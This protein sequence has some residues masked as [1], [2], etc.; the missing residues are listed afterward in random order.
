MQKRFVLFLVFLM[1]TAGVGALA[2]GK[3]AAAQKAAAPAQPATTAAPPAPAKESSKEQKEAAPGPVI[4]QQADRLLRQMSDY[5]KAAKQFSFHAEISYDD[6]LPSGQKLQLAATDEV[7]VRRPDRIYSEFEGETGGKRFWYD[8]KTITLYDSKHHVYG[9]E[10]APATIDAVLD[11]L[12][13]VLGFSPPFSDLL[14]SDPYAI[15]T[16]NVQYGFYAG[17]TQVEG[18]RCHHLAFQEKKIDWQVWIE[19]GVQLVPCKLVITYKTL[20]GAPQFIAVFSHWDLMAPAPDSMFAANLPASADRIT[21][22]AT[23]TAEKKAK[24]GTP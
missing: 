10:E 4:G 5:L 2:Y 12:M 14:H 9:T 20:P 24:G 11:H 19:D 17:L 15:L 21:F 7:L 6:L 13:K 22:Q 3:Q 18:Q 16:K 23:A 1:L 8:G